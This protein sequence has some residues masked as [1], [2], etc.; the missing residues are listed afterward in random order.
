MRIFNSIGE[1]SLEA[2]CVRNGLKHIYSYRVTSLASTTQAD[3]SLFLA[4]KWV[5]SFWRMKQ[6]E[7]GNKLHDSTHST[8]YTD[9]LLFFH[10]YARK[11]RQ[12]Y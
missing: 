6:R 3:L 1:R 8:D 11:Y 9:V 10:F 4:T 2:R 7:G 5:P 12:S